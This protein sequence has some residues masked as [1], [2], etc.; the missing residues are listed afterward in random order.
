MAETMKD[1]E[2]ELEASFKK[3]EEGDILTGTVISVDEK[4]VVLDLKYYAEGIIPAEDYSRE[5]GFNI[6]EEVHVGDEI[7]ATVVKKDDGHGNI[8]LSK[9]EATDV[10][11]WDK[12]KELKASGEVLDVVVKGAVNGGVVAYVEGVRGF[13][14]ASKLALNYVEDTNEYLNKRIQVQV[15]D[16]NKEDKKLILSAKEILRQKAEEERKN[17]ISNVEVGLVTEGVVESLQTYGAFVNLGNGLS[18]LV[19]ISQICEKRIR[20]PSEVLAV[21]DKVKVKV[22][23]VKDGK[24]SLSIKEASDAM[25][26]EIEEET[27]ELPDSGEQATTSLG[28]LFANIKLN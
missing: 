12:L 8:L 2:A 28:S 14:P 5:P 24:L 20:K 23:A 26:K 10:L 18:G 7:S 16:V 1:Y 21:G 22:T 27:V 15:I 4:E 6:K 9:V 17:K 19:H 25:A 11:A 13:I 3:I